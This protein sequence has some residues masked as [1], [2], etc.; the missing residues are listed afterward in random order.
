MLPKPPFRLETVPL[1]FP[2]TFRCENLRGECAR[3]SFSHCYGFRRRIYTFQPRRNQLRKGI[4]LSRG[5][6]RLMVACRCHWAAHQ[7]WDDVLEA[8]AYLTRPP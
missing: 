7:S 4:Y 3:W 5:R 6:C 2:A 8:V 1:E